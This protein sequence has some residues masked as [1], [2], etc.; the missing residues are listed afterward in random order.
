[1]SRLLKVI[2]AVQG[3]SM[4]ALDECAVQSS[5]VHGPVQYLYLP[6]AMLSSSNSFINL[7]KF[8]AGLTLP[9]K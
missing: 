9:L 1:M 2:P 8:M 4:H 6:V 3:V 5:P 7:I